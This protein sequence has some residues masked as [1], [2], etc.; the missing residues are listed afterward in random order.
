MPSKMKV[1]D[2]YGKLTVLEVL[3]KAKS[4]C[5]CDCGNK[6]VARNDKLKCGSKKSCGCLQGK[7]AKPKHGKTGSK[8]YVVWQNI[9]ARCR[10]PYCKSYSDYGARGIDIC[11]D[12]YNSF[13]CFYNYV[14]PAPSKNH[15]IGRIDN[16]GD[17]CPGNVR[18]ESLSEQK[19]NK[20]W[21]R[22]INYKGKN[23]KL[24]DFCE[25]HNYDLILVRSRLDQ[26]WSLEK[27]ISEPKKTQREKYIILDGKKQKLNDLLEFYGVK[28]TTYQYR[29]KKGFS[30]LEAL[31]KKNYERK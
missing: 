29:I 17:Y 13:E 21:T 9:K 8:E 30:P 15:S 18:W 2:K 7:G 19:R 3:P 1:G 10:K 27:A 25:K 24:I 20:S 14:G 22:W 26:G 4:V 12:W 31:T 6:C 28:Y 11:D 23:I 5:L 16:D